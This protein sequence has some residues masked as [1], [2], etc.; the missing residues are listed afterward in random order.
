M[1]L[2][3]IA[4]PECGAHEVYAEDAER[5]C[6]TCGFAWTDEDYEGEDSEDE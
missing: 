6:W 3:T 2:L 4:C 5:Q 1:K